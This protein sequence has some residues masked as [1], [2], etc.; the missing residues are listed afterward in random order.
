VDN[1]NSSWQAER[2]LCGSALHES[3]AITKT[4]IVS[5]IGVFHFSASALPYQTLSNQSLRFAPAMMMIKSK[6]A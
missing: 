2:E 3:G 1:G 5:A 4:P 6:P